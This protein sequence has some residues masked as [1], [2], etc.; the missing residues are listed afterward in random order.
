MLLPFRERS[1]VKDIMDELDANGFVEAAWRR[2][3]ELE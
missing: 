2:V 3:G 1:K